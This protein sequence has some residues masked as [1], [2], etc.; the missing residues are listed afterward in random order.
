VSGHVRVEKHSY[1]GSCVVCSVS[2]IVSAANTIVLERGVI[3]KFT[4]QR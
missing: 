2:P 4:A 1:F 3:V